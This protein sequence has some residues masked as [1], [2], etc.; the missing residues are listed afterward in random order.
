[1]TVMKDSEAAREA[2]LAEIVAKIRH[3]LVGDNQQKTAAETAP[4]LQQPTTGISVIRAHRLTL[5]ANH[6][7][8]DEDKAC[9]WLTEPHEKFGDESLLQLAENPAI[10]DHL[11][12]ALRRIHE[13][14]IFKD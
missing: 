3:I 14:Q 10:A 2:K 5:L 12:E 1:M 4:E 11:E 8:G 13:E 6:V 9:K 7:F